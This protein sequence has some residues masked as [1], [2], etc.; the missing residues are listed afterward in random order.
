[1]T[2]FRFARAALAAAILAAVAPAQSA[3]QVPRHTLVAPQEI[4]LYVHA[5]LQNMQF[6]DPLI[7][8]L[9]RALLAPVTVRRIGLPLN[10]ELL[11]SST[12]LDTN[13]IA[14]RFIRATAGDGGPRTFKY[15]LID[16]DMKVPELRYLFSASYG[17]HTT[18]YRVGIVST[19]RIAVA[20]RGG[21][22]ITAHR[23]YKL[24]LKSVAQVA[25][26]LGPQG[27][28]LSFPRSLP[29]LDQKSA[30]FCEEDR[31]ALVEAGILRAQEGAACAPVALERSWHQTRTG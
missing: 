22:E 11:A 8:A 27:C 19:A 29:E 31:R 23:A 26:Y 13:K 6:I 15:L 16:R 3:A 2:A 20:G 21:G 10:Q 7:C 12:Q 17:N 25:G 5:E 9:E 28:I 14:D 18:P 24:V 1:M 4:V 30:E